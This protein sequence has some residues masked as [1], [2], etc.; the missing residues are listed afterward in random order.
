MD[1]FIITGGRPLFG[2]VEVSTSKN[3]V[4]PILA[5]SL[6]TKEEVI[7]NKVPK[8]VDLFK[9]IE[10]IKSLGGKVN[11]DE[12]E[13]KL[14]IKNDN[15]T[16]Y[17]IPH[18]LA[19]DIRSSIFMLGPMLGRIK[20]AKV[21]YP[22]G[23][24]IGSRPIDLHLFG[25]RELNAKITEEYGFIVCEGTNLKSG[26]VHLDYPSVGATENIMMAA[27]LTKG[28]TIILN[29]AKEP[30]IVDLQNFINSMGGKV[31]GAGTNKIVVK[32]VS[33][34]HG[35]KYTPIGDRI[36]AG[37]LM[38]AS[39][40]TKGK[41]KLSNI[42]V[43]HV[44][45]LIN[46]LRKSGCNIDFY[47]GIISVESY[48]RPK[49]V[50]FDTQPYP[51]FPTDL[52]PLLSVYLATCKGV[53]VVTENLFETRFRYLQELLKMG[54]KVTFRDRTALIK[55]VHQLYGAQVTAHDLRGSAALCLAGLSAKGQTTIEN[56]NYL[57]RGYEDFDVLLNSLGMDIKRINQV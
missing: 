25:L 38:V 45:S 27:V 15:L 33:K 19:A 47:N 31:E 54:A 55:G 7:I 28:E 51:G 18:F 11:Y 52:Q 10:I 30:E 56:I 32:G 29:P 6:L 42:N 22:G 35:T 12:K 5:A 23:C 40:I 43:E 37:T 9:M 3:S 8:I 26:I 34:L 41:I 48:K 24:D 57:D 13:K 20:K 50:S 46:K 16:G 2:E 44:F 1:K 14:S 53:S 21:S 36:V 39:A 4:L 17:E 49:A